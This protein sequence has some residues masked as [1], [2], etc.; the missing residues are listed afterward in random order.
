MIIL[1]DFFMMTV[2]QR[3]ESAISPSGIITLNTAWINDKTVERFA[4]KRIYGRI[5]SCPQD[6]SDEIVNLIDPG[7]PAPR[8]HIS[9]EHIQNMVNL[10]YHH[11]NNKFYCCAGMDDFDRVTMTDV[12]KNTDIRRFD[13]C[14]FDSTITE[15]ANLLGMH[16]GKE[17]YKIG[18]H[19]VICTV[20]D[21][22]ILMQGGW[23][24]VKPDMETWHEITTKAGIIKKPRPEAKALRGTMSYMQHKDGLAVGEKIIF[25]KGA[26]WLI[27]VEG[28]EYYAIHEDD[29]LCKFA[30]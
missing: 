18:V 10:G 28:K 13:K 27:K 14:Y 30:A 8:K 26:N 2:D 3:Y 16:N 22:E 29:I 9:G 24:L 6:F 4:Y 25:C 17:L 12:A 1:R 20:R 21:N 19:Q 5:E 15:P 11:Y 23:C 7:V